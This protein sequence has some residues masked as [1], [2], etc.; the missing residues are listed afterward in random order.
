MDSNFLNAALE[1]SVRP[2]ASACIGL[3]D[4]PGP[5]TRVAAESTFTWRGVL[6]AVLDSGSRCIQ[7]LTNDECVFWLGVGTFVSLFSIAAVNRHPYHKIRAREMQRAFTKSVQRGHFETN[8]CCPGTIV[9]RT[10]VV[11]RC[12]SQK[13]SDGSI[14]TEIEEVRHGNRWSIGHRMNITFSDVI[15]FEVS[16][17]HSSA[18]KTRL[19]LQLQFYGSSFVHSVP[20]HCDTWNSQ[21][22]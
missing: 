6:D 11:R 8:A 21:T 16:F 15:T 4:L 3:R 13:R 12:I 17:S 7:G 1:Q 10:V 19:A 2:W 9:C 5:L 14:Q 20:G 18:D 22:V